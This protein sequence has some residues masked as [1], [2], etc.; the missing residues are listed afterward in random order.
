MKPLI[1]NNTVIGE[2]VPKICVPVVGT[3][4]E[5][6]LQDYQTAAAQEPDLIEW[7]ADCL[8]EYKDEALL[9]DILHAMRE[10][11]SDVT[12]LFTLRSDGEGG[13]ASV[14]DEEYLQLNQAVI[15][16]GFA[17]MSK[18]AAAGK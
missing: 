8:H 18:A 1:V 10:G 2:G 9:I 3:T 4:A 14:S 15:R 13:N 12:I 16:S 6:V 11:Y 17:E 5:E 7:R